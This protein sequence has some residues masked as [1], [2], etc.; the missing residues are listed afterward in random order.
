MTEEFTRATGSAPEDH[1]LCA[2][3]IKWRTRES[4]DV[5]YWI[6]P[7]KDLKA[8]Y[9]PK[10]IRLDEPTQEE[11]AARCRRL[12]KGLVT[13]R[14][15]QGQAQPVK[16]TVGWLVE[17]YLNDTLS[18][19]TALRVRTQR[20][21]KAFCEIIKRDI[22]TV[23]LS[24]KEPI[25]GADVRRWHALWGKPVDGQPTTPARA[26][27]LIVQLRILASYAV[28]IGVP[29]AK[30]FRDLLGVMRFATVA[31]RDVA[32]T[33]EQ[34]TILVRVASEMGFRSIAMTTLAQFELIERRTHIIGTWEDDQW[35]PGWL[36]SDV[37]K[38]WIIRYYQNKTGR[39]L[40]EFDLKTVPALLALMQETAPERRVG[41][42]V[43]CE[44]TRK[45]WTDRYYATVFR[46]IARA[47]GV[48]DE[49]QSMDMRAGG[50]TE[51]DGVEGVTD[52][53]LQD[54]GG[55][56]DPRT[57][58][59]YRRGKS[60]NAQNVVELRQKARES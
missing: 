34:V 3:G 57:R 24:L 36:W 47:A 15:L 21:Y 45:P 14:D 46:K 55:W 20:S 17:R 37:S 54:A 6:P 51:A 9:A 42:V 22:G 41:P 10:S 7:A 16:H 59:R 27:H 44:T 13:W 2:P 29:A 30:P 48:P 4:G 18:P 33:R 58:D 25:T 60:R 5:A 52:R 28:E 39:N 23:P 8:G 26:R 19:Y 35:R 1:P 43:I 50:A 53:A 40:R 11:I 49:I 56:K 32:P 12:W 38:D 31:A